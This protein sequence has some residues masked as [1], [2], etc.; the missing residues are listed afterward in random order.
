MTGT[1]ISSATFVLASSSPRRAQLLTEAGYRFSVIEP[2]I[3]EPTGPVGHLPPA[4]QAEA[5]A[6]FKA[7]SVVDAARP[8]LPVLGADTVVALGGEVFGKPRDAAD[9]RAMLATLAGT[10]HEV[11][12][13][14]A[15]IGAGGTRLLA[16]GVTG[17]HMRRLSKAELDAYIAGGGWEGKAGSYGIQDADDPFVESYEGSFTN[18]VGLPMEMLRG[19]FAQ[20]VM[21]HSG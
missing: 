20:L 2:P 5:L 18:V 19:L 17:V 11:I 10:R 6:Y 13:G 9:A 16:S 14:V 1:P 15:L 21:R 7:R 8:P 12:T 4:Q 3:A